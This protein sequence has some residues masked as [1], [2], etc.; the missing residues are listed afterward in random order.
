MNEVEEQPS[1]LSQS[2]INDVEERTCRPVRHRRKPA[3]MLS[4]DY[5][6]EGQ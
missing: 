3:W 1:P 4:G 2:D 5:E 6:T